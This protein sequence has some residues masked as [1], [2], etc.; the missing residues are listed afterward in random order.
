MAQQMLL[1]NSIRY[2]LAHPEARAPVRGTP[3]S[4]GLDVFACLCDDKTEGHPSIEISPHGGRTAV[5]TGL[6][7]E[8]PPG[9]YLRV[10]DR[11]SIALNHGVI[12]GGGVIDPDYRG[13]IKVI[14][15]NLG[16][17]PFIVHHGDK[18][19]QLVLERCG[20]GCW[21]DQLPLLQVSVLAPTVRGRGGFGSTNGPT[22]SIKTFE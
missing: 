7:M 8:P 1:V 5:C 6:M 4:V 9:T 14:L 19:A 21:G 17:E 15:L 3:H 2:V 20:N 18:I 11:S 12:I 16:T 22:V 10:A 13:V